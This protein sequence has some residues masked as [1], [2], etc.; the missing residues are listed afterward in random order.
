MSWCI[1]QRPH[2]SYCVEADCQ[3]GAHWPRPEE[4]LPS[5]ERLGLLSDVQVKRAATYQ[6]QRAAAQRSWGA[7]AQAVPL[8]RLE[9]E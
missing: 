2:V 1:C 6:A 9:A 5:L 4:P 7:N 3:W 8:L